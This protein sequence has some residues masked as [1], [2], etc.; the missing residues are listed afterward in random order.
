[1]D[2]QN[3]KLISSPKQSNAL[4]VNLSEYVKILP[5]EKEDKKGWVNYGE[6]NAYPNYIIELY[7]ESPVHGALINSIAFM[8]AGNGL[9]TSIQAVA[10][11]IERLNLEKILFPMAID[12][13]MQGGCYL[14]II[15]TL[16]RKDI[17]EV[18]YLPYENCRLSKTPDEEVNGIW[19]SNDWKD[20]RKK[21]NI[22][23]YVPFFDINKATQEPK[24]ILFFHI[25]N[26]GAGYYPKPDYIQCINWIELTRHISEYHVNN[27]LNG[28][29]P[30]FMIHFMNGDQ[31]PE[32]KA[33]IK[34]DW[35]EMISG[36]QNAGK[37]I[38]T[39]NEDES[40]APRVD[41]FPISDADKQYQYLSD[42]ATKQ[43][44][45]GHRVTSPLLFGIR[46]NGGLGSN[47]DEM[48]SALAIF[49][50]YVI[51]PYQDMITEALGLIIEA[52]GYPSDIT[53]EKKTL[54]E[55]EMDA[56]KISGD[57][58]SATPQAVAT[59]ALNGAKITS[60]LD[61]ITQTTAKVL[62]IP[63]AKAITRASFPFLTDQQISDIF[64]NLSNVPINP[65]QVLQGAEKKKIELN[66]KGKDND[67]PDMTDEI[68]EEW[69]N[70]LSSCGE[71]IDTDEW[72]LVDIEQ[73]D[74][75]KD[76]R[77]I[78]LRKK[79]SLFTKGFSNPGDKSI[80]DVGLFKVRYSYSE[81]I[82]ENSRNF[83]IKMVQ[84]SKSGL[85]YRYEDINNMSDW[86]I[87]NQFAK[88]GEDS[89]SIW[90]WKG[91]KNCH[92]RWIREIYK[93]KRVKGRFL[94]N[95]GIKNDEIIS[96][97]RALEEGVGFKDLKYGWSKASTPTID[98]Q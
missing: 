23:E 83:C 92:H 56:K 7:R 68:E 89:Y 88:S 57:T 16:D 37:F 75:K 20:T 42:E 66:T 10:D 36:V 60:L 33:K 32:A 84:A 48:K 81:N 91:G 4:Q 61:I 74:L 82:S 65:E 96:A 62:T 3:T 51:K 29:F 70:H 38:M 58:T 14:E 5:I 44:M 2:N 19:Y 95:D 55:E 8:I 6:N 21:R 11:L 40:R 13:K 39:F 79:E 12:L 97:I 35:E 49:N 78:S 59:Q 46:D 27:I 87:N 98:L 94:P 31:S 54:W 30:S 93:R 64:D 9:E 69:L 22:P 26:C 34:E 52:L 47:K 71:L 17:S 15:Y 45:M 63:S 67:F 18:N 25:E 41:T 43:I 85:K 1:M 72:E 90:L 80:M 76:E 28:L 24:Q 86:G 77:L 50:T 73:V 53:I